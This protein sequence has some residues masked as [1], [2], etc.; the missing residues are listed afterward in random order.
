MSSKRAFENL[1]R[2]P[3]ELL[4]SLVAF[5]F[6]WVCFSEADLIALEPNIALV[7]SLALCLLGLIRL[8]LG[9]RILF[10]QK[11]LLKLR[12]FSFS[13]R[14]VPCSDK[15]LYIGKGF[16]WLP[17]HRQRLFLLS[18]VL[19]E[20]FL[21]KS[22][23]YQFVDRRARENKKGFCAWLQQQSFLPF[24]PAPAIGGK[25]WIHAVGSDV[26]HNI[27]IK[28][29]NRNSHMVVFGRTRVG[30]TRLMSILLN[31]D[32]QNGEAVLIID[33][34]GDLELLQDIYS[35]C[36]VSGRLEDLKILHTGFPE[37]SA[38]YNPLSA[39]MNISEVATRVTNAISA[40]GEGKQF[41][42]FAWKFLNI[43][44]TCLAEMNESID[45][46][47]LAFFV[48]RPKQLL[49]AYCDKVLPEIDPDYLKGVK[50]IINEHAG[51]VDKK[52]NALPPMAR[53]DAV[54]SYVSNYI[55]KV[56][57]TGNTSTLLGSTIA[58][59]YHA[60][61][62]GDEYYGKITASLGPV[63]D[64]INKT[65]AGEIFSWKNSLGLPVIELEAVIKRKQIVYIGLD[66]LSNK[67]M[68]DAVGQATISDL[69]SLCGRMYKDPHQN[70]S[71]KLH[72]D[73][74]SE[75]VRDEFITL[76]NKAGGAGI[77]VTAYTQTVNDLGVVFGS[78]QDK[79]KMLLGNFGTTIMMRISNMD[80][81][82]VFTECL[83]DVRARTRTPSTMSNDR[84][85]GGSGEL[86][87]TYNTDSIVEEKTD[88]IVEND[89][90]SLPV[91]QAFVLTN[92]G[93]LYKV[94]IPL[95]TSG[96]IAPSS[97]E[98][99]IHE[100]NLCRG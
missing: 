77:H 59:L 98:T 82:K 55:E 16:R 93:E 2:T 66:S 85:K 60:A 88:L 29:S 70:L 65:P 74:F 75:I 36:S 23:L 81:A 52:G 96:S 83:E 73:E 33:P 44:A 37:I 53:S 18:N 92:G 58:D 78:N 12:P 3:W 91:G 80:T 9:L 50:A 86:F 49:L 43:V 25:P 90:F 71:L 21:Q 34:K 20:K 87:T 57:S 48:T 62:I 76:L 56:I 94:R 100:V 41:A 35:A 15:H 32:I 17:I 84:G 6:A 63:F 39:Y 7:T 61:K 47:N 40:E 38:K 99:L 64:K 97:F 79:P 19:N 67:A 89:L 68:S 11:R 14:E 8:K 24:K 28:Q 69:V 26:E 51:K 95:P 46:Q 72:A 13:T 5:S 10:Y 31:Q 54:R 27:S 42:D 22:R 1:L 30:K 4:V 45:Y